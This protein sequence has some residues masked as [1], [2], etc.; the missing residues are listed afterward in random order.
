LDTTDFVFVLPTDFDG[1][2]CAWEGVTA[3]KG[4]CY[5]VNPSSVVAAG[6]LL[7]KL[8]HPLDKYIRTLLL[9]LPKSLLPEVVPYGGVTVIDPV[10]NKY[11]ELLQDPHG[12]DISFLTGVTVHDNKLYLG[13]LH[14]NVIGVYDLS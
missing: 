10:S 5:A 14:N 8:P 6:K 9:A 4:Y 7:S 12:S 2:D 11:I 3:N 1:V 13:S